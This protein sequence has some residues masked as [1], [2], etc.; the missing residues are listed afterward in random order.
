MKIGSIIKKQRQA[1]DLTQEQLAE[2]L[3]VSVSAVSQWESGKTVPDI[4]TILSLANFFSIT[5]DELFDRTSGDKEKAMEEYDRLD[6]EYA[7]RGEVAKQAALWREAVQKYPGDFHCLSS[8]AHALHEAVYSGGDSEEIENNA[9][10]CVAISERILRDCTD[11]DIRDSAIQCLVHMHSHK[12]LSIA[13]EEKAV[14][15]ANMAGCMFTSRQ[16]LLESAYFT[17]E[18]KEKKRA[19]K[20]RNNLDYMDLLTMNLYYGQYP[21]EEEKIRACRAALALWEALIYDGNYLFFHCRIQN[22]YSNMAWGYA[23]LQNR[24]ETIQA[25]KMAM[26]HAK[27]Y[28]EL[29]AGEQHYTSVL[30][31]AATSDT[32]SFSKNYTATNQQ[33]VLTFMKN[34]CF[35]FV[36]DDPAFV[37]L[38]EGGK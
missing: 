15:Y 33:N 8:L 6:R 23:K 11:S 1:L 20:H 9:K 31:N 29:P 4:A 34:K 2:Y 22:I 26:H 30:V 17:E 25:L 24:E 35:D 28:D 37:E 16:E 7:N 3:N 32:A 12:D 18:S 13:N 38:A 27:C 10:E 36:R 14:Q 19:V 21:N 5:L